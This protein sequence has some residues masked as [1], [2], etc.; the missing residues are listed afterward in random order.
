MAKNDVL[1]PNNKLINAEP[2][3]EKVWQ[4]KRCVETKQQADKR[5]SKNRCSMANVRS[6]V[7]PIDMVIKGF[8]GKVKVGPE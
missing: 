1:R 3:I 8:L 2:I 5:K 4:K 6:T 7:K